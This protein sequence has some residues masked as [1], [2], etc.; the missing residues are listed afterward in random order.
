M[1][2][3]AIEA[4][5]RGK[6]LFEVLSRECRS[7]FRRL[8]L[9][10][11]KFA[12]VA[13]VKRNAVPRD[14]DEEEPAMS[15]AIVHFMKGVDD[16]ID[17]CAERLRDRELA[18]EPLLGLAPIFHPIGQPLVVDDDEEIIVRLIAFG[19]MRLIDEGAASIRAVEDD[20][21]D[22]ALLLP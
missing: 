12:V 3:A 18:V 16:E 9:G 21:E 19:G 11:R 7:L 6:P 15:K 14:V 2:K 20:L 22:P 13:L 10:L 8:G 5:G 4:I 1:L 17:G